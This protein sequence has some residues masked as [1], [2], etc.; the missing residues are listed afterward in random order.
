[1]IG[2]WTRHSRCSQIVQ[3]YGDQNERLLI[4]CEHS[5]LG[6]L[7]SYFNGYK[8][9][10]FPELCINQGSLE[11]IIKEKFLSVDI[12][13]PSTSDLTTAN[14]KSL[15]SQEIRTLDQQLRTEMILIVLEQRCI[16]L[17]GLVD[18]VKDIQQQI[19]QMK[20]KY[21]STTVKLNFEPRQV[22]SDSNEQGNKDFL[23]MLSLDYIST[24]HSNQ[25]IEIPRSSVFEYKNR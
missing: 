15:F 8:S 19:Q 24:Q 12:A 11:Q 21:A 16:H 23:L 10:E 9:A 20:S 13:L 2:F 7:I 14:E 1:M 25:C 5:P 4:V 3:S 6:L 22:E 18:K 17:F